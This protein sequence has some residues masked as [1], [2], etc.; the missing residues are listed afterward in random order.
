M[1]HEVW[2]KMLRTQAEVLSLFLQIP[3]WWWRTRSSNRTFEEEGEGKT[4]LLGFSTCT[5]H[6]NAIF[7]KEAWVWFELGIP[8]IV[9][10]FNYSHKEPEQTLTEQYSCTQLVHQG[11]AL[12]ILLGL[13]HGCWVCFLCPLCSTSPLC[14]P[15]STWS[16]AAKLHRGQAGRKSSRKVPEPTASAFLLQTSVLGLGSCKGMT[17]L[18]HMAYVFNQNNS[19]FEY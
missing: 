6:C 11:K 14:F 7:L 19:Y 16:K 12:I 18:H 8:C 4:G 1:Y 10:G 13:G 9:E 3:Q 15:L 17:E 2:L 5:Q